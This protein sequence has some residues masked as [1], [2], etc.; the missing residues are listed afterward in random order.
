ML[1]VVGGTL[2]LGKSFQLLCH[3]DSGTLPI[4]Y[5]L[6]SPN[7]QPERR[8]VSRPEDR[9]VFNSS[10]IYKTSDLNKFMC[11]AINRQDEPPVV[12]SGQ[13]LQRPIIIGVLDDTSFKQ[14]G[15]NIVSSRS[16]VHLTPC[17]ACVKT[18]VDD[19]PQRRLRGAGLD[20]LVLRPE[21]NSSHQI[22]LVPH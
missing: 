18:S 1:S 7:G 19:A 2:V 5:T 20:S 16:N 14:I 11:H 17:R 15:V 13:Q 3:S 8:V 22:H 21:R 9:A 4:I 6:F 10:A 12:A